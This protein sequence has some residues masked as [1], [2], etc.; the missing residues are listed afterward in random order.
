MAL[1]FVCL[2]HILMASLSDPLVVT[3]HK[4]LFLW[5]KEF[6]AKAYGYVFENPMILIGFKNKCIVVFG[7]I[8]NMI[9]TAMGAYALSRRGV[10]GTTVHHVFI[11]FTM[12]FSGG[13]ASILS[14]YP[15]SGVCLS[16]RSGADPSSGCERLTTDCYAHG[17]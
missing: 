11:V 3:Q 17:L 10:R 15:K 7:T 9:L 14:E 8:V 16:F 5:P 6:T 1:F 2:I 4:G 12:F 13:V